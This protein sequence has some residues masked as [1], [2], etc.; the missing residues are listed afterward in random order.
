VEA[1]LHVAGQAVARPR[2]ALRPA[3]LVVPARLAEPATLADPR[4]ELRRAGPA[5]GHV[6]RRVLLAVGV[7][8]ALV[9]AARLAREVDARLP[10]DQ[11]AVEV[12]LAGRALIALQAR[13]PQHADGALEPRR[14]VRLAVG[15]DRLAVGADPDAGLRRLPAEVV[16]PLL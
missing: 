6:A 8:R 9:R 1:L 3:V 16:V 14:A 2:R 4:A 5:H 10:V 11:R 13:L 15:A 12:R 7:R